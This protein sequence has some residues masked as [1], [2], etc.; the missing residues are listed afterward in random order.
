[1]GR[2]VVGGREG[3]RHAGGGDHV[4]DV[5]AALPVD[6]CPEDGGHLVSTA[7]AGGEV[8]GRVQVLA[9]GV[10]EQTDLLVVRKAL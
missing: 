4:R 8:G 7:G 5:T 2:V 9:G 10:L 1:M 3:G 6:L